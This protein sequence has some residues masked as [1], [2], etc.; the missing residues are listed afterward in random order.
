MNGKGITAAIGAIGA[1]LATLAC[2]LPVGLVGAAG[3]AATLA[4]VAQAGRP[5]LLG[6]SFVFLGVGFA[7]AWHSNR[8]GVKPNRVALALLI[9][10]VVVLLLVLLFPQLIAGWLADWGGTE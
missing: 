2:C 8:C 7:Q 3:V 4:A 6:L 1:S 5:W 10:A 9:F